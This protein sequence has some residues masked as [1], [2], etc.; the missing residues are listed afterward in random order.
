MAPCDVESVNLSRLKNCAYADRMSK[1]FT[2][3]HGVKISLGAAKATQ[4]RFWNVGAF[5]SSEQ[6]RD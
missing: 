3:I 5:A 2:L 4:T 6:P 1:T